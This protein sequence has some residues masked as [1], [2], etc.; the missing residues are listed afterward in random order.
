[1]ANA[2]KLLK[3]YHAVLKAVPTSVTKH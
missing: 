1:M 2:F 3:V